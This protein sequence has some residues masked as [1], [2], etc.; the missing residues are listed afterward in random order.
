MISTLL[1]EIEESCGTLDY[2]DRKQNLSL[3]WMFVVDISAV[4]I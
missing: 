4:H 3:V 2:G 1:L